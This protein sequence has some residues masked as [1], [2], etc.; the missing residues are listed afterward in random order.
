MTLAGLGV[1]NTPLVPFFLHRGYSVEVHTKELASF[2]PHPKVTLCAGKEY[3]RRFDGEIVFRSPGIR[4][5]GEAFDRARQQGI[6]VLTEAGAFLSLSPCPV[7][8]VTGSDGKTTTASLAAALLRASG[9]TVH[10]GGNIGDPLLYRLSACKSNHIAVA[11]LSSFQLYDA[12]CSPVSAVLTN[13]SENHLNWH[14]D[15]AEYAAAKAR[16]FGYPN[17]RAVLSAD[18]EGSAPFRLALPQA[19][20]F[21]SELS[22]E[23]LRMR[24]GP[25]EYFYPEGD[26]LLRMDREGKTSVIASYRDFRLPG[27]HNLRNLLAAVALTYPQLDPAAVTAVCRQF[28]GV[29]HRMEIVAEE[30]GVTYMNSSVD[31]SPSRTAATLAAIGRPAVVIAGGAKK[32]ISLL[33]LCDAFARYAKAVFLTGDTAEEIRDLL[34]S[35]LRFR[36]TGIPVYL[37]GDFEETVLAACRIAEKGDTVVLSPGCT[38]F[39]RFRNF[40]ERG[41]RFRTI[42]RQYLGDS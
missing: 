14:R 34:L 40:E 1:S 38:S 23:T 4:P 13:L 20:L 30:A 29:P 26:D 37:P 22:G 31:S 15:F 42:V 5:E 36:Q 12:P 2:P 39:D 27:R 24:Y 21:S 41:E 25:R 18:D 17:R 6:P 19:A 8:A 16:I 35:S 28:T 10:L 9:R 11:E 33:P 3:L 7:Y 32:G